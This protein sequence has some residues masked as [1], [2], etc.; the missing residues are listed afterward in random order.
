[1]RLTSKHITGVT[2]ALMVLV[3]AWTLV[4]RP[5]TSSAKDYT[6]PNDNFDSATLQQIQTDLQQYQV[7][8]NP[9]DHEVYTVTGGIGVAN[10]R[11]LRWGSDGNMNFGLNGSPGEM[12]QIR[13]LGQ[14]PMLW[15][16]E[17]PHGKLD[18]Q[19]KKGVTFT[20]K[21]VHWIA[22]YTA[23]GQVYYKLDD[24][25]QGPQYFFQKENTYIYVTSFP[26]D[27]FPVGLMNHLVPVGN[28]VTK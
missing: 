22:H 5:L 24:P 1:M 27:V 3:T 10:P 9:Q 19:T 25:S 17:I 2:I 28:P 4:Y 23:T 11:I 12:Y 6:L 20:S 8:Q 18:P 13:E 7:S 15:K 14:N 26:N 16:Q 21:P